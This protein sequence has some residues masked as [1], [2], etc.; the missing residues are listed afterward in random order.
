MVRRHLFC[1]ILH[2]LLAAGG[3]SMSKL[4]VEAASYREQVLAIT[5]HHLGTF[6]VYLRWISSFPHQPYRNQSHISEMAV[7]CTG[8]NRLKNHVG[9]IAESRALLGRT[10]LAVAAWKLSLVNC[11]PAR[12]SLCTQG[13]ARIT[14]IQWQPTPGENSEGASHQCS[15]KIQHTGWEP[16]KISS[17]SPILSVSY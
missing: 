17:F 13:C 6:A 5:C 15:G 7:P 8:D 2:W 9:L 14:L 3:A 11:V 4:L 1:Y 12:L 10:G 16:R